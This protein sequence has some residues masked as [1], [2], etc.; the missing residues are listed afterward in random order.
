[1]DTK[2]E[3]NSALTLCH[4]IEEKQIIIDYDDSIMDMRKIIDGKL[5]DVFVF[6]LRSNL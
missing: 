2:E 3:K 6:L 4:K 5:W 1:M